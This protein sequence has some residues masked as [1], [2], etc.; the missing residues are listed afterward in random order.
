MHGGDFRI[1]FMQPEIGIRYTRIRDRRRKQKLR[2]IPLHVAFI[3]SSG[4]G[5][6]LFPWAGGR[7]WYDHAQPADG[8]RSREQ[9]SIDVF[10][11]ENAFAQLWAEA[12]ETRTFRPAQKITGS[13]RLQSGTTILSNVFHMDDCCP[14]SIL[15]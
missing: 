8:V 7:T 3:L 11:V 14:R 1:L 15:F 6:T 9:H 13:K 4:S 12:G 10:P 5:T 2:L